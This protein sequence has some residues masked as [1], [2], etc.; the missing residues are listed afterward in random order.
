MR[1]RY[2]FLV[3]ALFGVQAIGAQIPANRPLRIIALGAHPEG[4]ASAT[5]RRSNSTSIFPTFR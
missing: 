5:P 4:A 3:L 2:T 1:A